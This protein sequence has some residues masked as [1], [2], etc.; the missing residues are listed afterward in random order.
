MKSL[1]L[2]KLLSGTDIVIPKELSDI[3]FGICTE[4]E[5]CSQNDILFITKTSS[6]KSRGI[7]PAG[8]S[9]AMIVCED[10]EPLDATDVPRLITENARRSLAIAASNLYQIDYEKVKLVGVTGTNGKT[11]TATM[12]R[13]ILTYDGHLCGFIGTGKIKIGDSEIQPQGYTMTTPDPLLLYKSIAAM[14]DAGCEY[15]V[16]E[17]SSHALMLEKLAPIR[18]EVG[19]FTNLSGEHLDFHADMES[20]YQAKKRLFERSACGIFCV[21]DPYSKR[22][23]DEVECERISVGIIN[24]ADVY[25]TDICLMGLSGSK[26]F[27]REK[28]RIFGLHLPYVGAF[29]VYNALMAIKCAIRLGVRPCIAKAAMTVGESIDGRMEMIHDDVTVIIDY[30]HTPD[31]LENALKT[32]YSA[33]KPKQKLRVVFGCGG[34]RDS[35]KRPLM[36]IVASKYADDI[37]LT[38]DNSRDEDTMQ[39]IRDIASGIPS[40][41]SYSIIPR[42]SDAITEAILSAAKDDIIAVF[43][44][45][46]ERYIIDKNGMR[47]FDERV[48]INTALELRRSKNEN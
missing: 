28:D 30:A 34:N 11:T 1:T 29:N 3:P 10:D 17:V 9:A 32:L 41:A 14:Q 44:K 24:S 20:Y 48:I 27:Y 6:G 26:I 15:I 35:V 39:I 33:K 46:H 4:P 8:C 13:N 47:V 43:G 45:G 22:A 16:M 7:S 23:Y 31:A 19:L 40:Q 36:G 42:R 37:I 18:F 25:A 5:K 2:T 21:D 38:E 12:I